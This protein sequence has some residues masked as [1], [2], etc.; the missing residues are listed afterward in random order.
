MG[1]WW[2]LPS[3]NNQQICQRK[4]DYSASYHKNLPFTTIVSA[5]TYRL[6]HNQIQS[7]VQSST[8]FEDSLSGVTNGADQFGATIVWR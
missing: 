3:Y 1:N 2:E 6:R 8:T 5:A 7:F 4:L